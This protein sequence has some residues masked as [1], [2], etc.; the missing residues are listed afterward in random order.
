[1]IILRIK[2]YYHLVLFKDPIT[3]F[4]M[5]PLFP[6]MPVLK[7]R[8]NIALIILNLILTIIYAV[9]LNL[10]P[11]ADGSSVQRIA[12]TSSMLGSQCGINALNCAPFAGS[13]LVYCPDGCRSVTAFT[14]VFVGG[15]AIQ[16]VPLVIGEDIYRADSWIW[17]S[18]C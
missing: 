5:E 17:Y 14:P 8:N 10:P 13:Q 2:H 15:S 1:M 16:H 9:L 6:K 3:R 12:C 11:I 18:L 4:S 7:I